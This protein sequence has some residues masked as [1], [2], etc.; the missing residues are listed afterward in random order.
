MALT[1]YLYI[2]NK[3]IERLREKLDTKDLAPNTRAALLNLLKTEA[4]IVEQEFN[5]AIH[6]R[7]SELER[8]EETLASAEDVIKQGE[9]YPTPWAR[10]AMAMW[11]EIAD[12]FMDDQ[13]RRNA[14]LAAGQI[15]AAFLSTYQNQEK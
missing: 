8:R 12:A 13:T 4:R 14:I 11:H 5:A 1:S 2:S 7:L 3:A 9:Q 15:V 6:D 10:E